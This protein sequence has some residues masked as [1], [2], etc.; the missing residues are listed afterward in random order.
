MGAGLRSNLLKFMVR[1]GLLPADTVLLY[2]D[3]AF[4]W[5]SGFGEFA[6]VCYALVR[7]AKPQIVVEVGAAYGRSTCFIAAA[8]ER[9]QHGMLFSIDPH[10][11]TAW[12]DGIPDIDTYSILVSRLGDLRL[13]KYVQLMRIFSPVAVKH[14]KEPVDLL[15]LDGSHTFENVKA[16]FMGFLPFLNP[17]ALVL[18]HDSMWEYHQEHPLYRRDQGVPRLV[19]ELQDQGYPMVTLREGWGLTILQNSPSGF[20]LVP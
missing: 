6:Q 17:G 11:P 13:T 4:E 8:I 12:N 19:Q 5:H 1:V 10:E 15:L 2:D 20:K 18:F 16:D 3:K 14:W 7:S 9:N